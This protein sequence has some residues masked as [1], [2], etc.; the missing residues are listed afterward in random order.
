MKTDFSQGYRRIPS[1]YKYVQFYSGHKSWTRG[2]SC[3]SKRCVTLSCS[4]L[5]VWECN[6][7]ILLV[8]SF[9]GRWDYR[10]CDFN[11]ATSG[12]V[13]HWL[14]PKASC[15]TE[16]LIDSLC[17]L[18]IRCTTHILNFFQRGA[19]YL[20]GLVITVHQWQS[21]YLFISNIQ[22]QL[23]SVHRC[24]PPSRHRHSVLLKT[25]CHY[26]SI[27]WRTN[28]AYGIR[29]VSS[30]TTVHASWRFI[31]RPFTAIRKVLRTRLRS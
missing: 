6:T 2:E 16:H 5:R 24:L 12:H 15:K 18:W 25:D 28:S 23:A 21:S 26:T 30:S 3:Y 14:F 9:F 8:G 29:A 11:A 27:D 1:T 22:S 17:L 4:R 13:P 31:T 7:D 20:L 10:T 19:C